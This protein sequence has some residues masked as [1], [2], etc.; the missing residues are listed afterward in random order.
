MRGLFPLARRDDGPADLL[1]Q[2]D[3]AADAAGAGKC[4]DRHCAGR[5]EPRRP[6][7]GRAVYE[8][9]GQQ[10][11]L[12]PLARRDPAGGI[13]AADRRDARLCAHLGDRPGQAGDRTVHAGRAPGGSERDLCAGPF[14]RDRRAVPPGARLRREGT[15]APR[16]FR[17]GAG[18]RA[19]DHRRRLRRIYAV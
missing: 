17:Q 11:E 8:R 1:L 9:R 7:Y 12:D 5:G 19:G 3:A 18:L 10:P 2:S 13:P 6:V 16:R 15:D 14:A 4:E